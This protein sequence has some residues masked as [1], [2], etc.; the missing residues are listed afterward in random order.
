MSFET[1]P[2]LYRETRQDPS[3]MVLGIIKAFGFKR[4][5]RPCRIQFMNFEYYL[6]IDLLVLLWQ[7]FSLGKAIQFD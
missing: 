6:R 1:K 7:V 3:V 5:V 2:R 4:C